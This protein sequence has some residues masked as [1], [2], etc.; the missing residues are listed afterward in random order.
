MSMTTT[1]VIGFTNQVI[2]L[3]EENK[4]ELKTKGLDVATWIVI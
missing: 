1:E 4:A 3:F 2:Q